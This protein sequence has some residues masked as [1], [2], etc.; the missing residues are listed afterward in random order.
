NQA[1]YDE[2]TRR[3]LPVNVVDKPELC[4]FIFPSIVDRSPLVV[5]VSSGGNSPVLARL[6]RARLEAFIPSAYGM[7]AGLLGKYRQAARERFPDIGARMR[8][9][10]SMLSGPVAELTMSGQGSKAEVLLQQQL[11]QAGGEELRGEV[12]LV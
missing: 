7:L 5:A 4:S 8:F 1:V 3:N 12:Y 6:L 11:A 9:W 2:A 10:E